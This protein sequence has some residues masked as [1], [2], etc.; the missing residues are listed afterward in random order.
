MR[1]PDKQRLA[2]AVALTL[3]AAVLCSCS[4]KTAP[5]RSAASAEPTGSAV[6]SSVASTEGSQAAGSRS[7]AEWAGL[8]NG[9][10]VAQPAADGTAKRASAGTTPNAGSGPKSATQPTTALAVTFGNVTEAKPLAGTIITIGA[11]TFRPKPGAKSDRFVFRP[12][13]FQDALPMSVYPDGRDGRRIAID[14]DLKA[15]GEASAEHT[16]TVLVSDTSVMVSGLSP[17]DR[18][19]KY[20]RF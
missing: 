2:I 6:A 7:E 1:V 18:P 3:V 14:L 10:D 16:V 8:V 19:R 9:G 20:P 17:I 15:G 13:P 12:V 4:P 5:S 11:M